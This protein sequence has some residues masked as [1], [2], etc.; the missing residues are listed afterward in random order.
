M[1]APQS[2]LNSV[3]SSRLPTYRSRNHRGSY[4]NPSWSRPLTNVESLPVL[5]IIPPLVPDISVPPS[6]LSWPNPDH[7]AYHYSRS[8]H[9]HSCRAR[10]VAFPKW[11]E[12]PT[13]PR[14]LVCEGQEVLA[15]PN[16]LTS[17]SLSL[18]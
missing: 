18:P 4:R 7:A 12:F 15:C 14:P 17:F 2:P 5:P 3:S 13:K 9:P 6:C 8:P 1:A 11:F 10:P 16:R